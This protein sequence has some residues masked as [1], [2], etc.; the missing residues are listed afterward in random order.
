M[1][2]KT[3]ICP[4]SHLKAI[5]I[6]RL[7]TIKR[8][9]K[10]ILISTLGTTIASALGI[11]FYWMMLS[12]ID[13]ITNPITFDVFGDNYYNFAISGKSNDGFVSSIESALKKLFINDTKRQP[14]FFYF[15]SLNEMQ[16]FIYNHFD[17]K[18]VMGLDLSL[19]PSNVLILYNNT[20]YQG[21]QNPNSYEL[22]SIVLF[23]QALWFNE[24]NPNKT[25]Y[26]SFTSNSSNEPSLFDNSEF[27]FSYINFEYSSLNENMAK[28]IFSAIGPFLLVAGLLTCIPL[29]MYQPF[30]DIRGEVRQYMMQCTLRLFPYWFGTFIIDLSIWVIITTI[31]WGLLNL[32]WIRSFHDNLFSTW[33]VLAFQGPSMLLFFY[34][35]SFLFSSP[36]S[37]P[38][39]MYLIMVL[40]IFIGILVNMIIG[41][42]NPLGLDWFWSLIPPISLEQIISIIIRNMG[43]NKE[44]F[45]YYW[46]YQHS[47]PYLIMQ[48]VDIILYGIILAIIE[49][50]RIEIQ[51]R[52][53]KRTFSNYSEY[54]KQAKRRSVQ[55]DD[56]KEMEEAVHETNDWA[57]RI[58]DV[59][60]LFINNDKKPITAVNNVSLGIKEFSLFGFLGAN[61]AGK[62]TLINLI[63]GNIPPSAGKIELFGNNIEDIE[64]TTI[65]SIC[66]QFNSHLFLA[67]TPKEH[68]KIYSLL[69][70]M[71]DED[72]EDIIEDLISGMELNDFEDVPV[73]ELSIGDARKLGIALSFFGPSKL[74]ILD[75][76]TASLDPIACRCVQQ[77]ILEHKG[78]KT[79]ML[80]THILSEAEFLCDVISIMVR[81][82][83]YTIG[84]PQYLS[85]KYGKDYRI[86]INLDDATK[87]C[88]NKV[89]NFFNKELPDAELVIQRPKSQI[90]TIVL[91]S[92]E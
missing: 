83:I 63:A 17:S 55:S 23:G 66:P 32:G 14:N 35:F 12:W 6:R 75:E 58:V 46:H 60:R 45:R 62:T 24:F 4:L 86:D 40:A 27:N 85:E 50:N 10:S 48:W 67:L 9:W 84:S 19:G 91:C 34:C 88:H 7:L 38:R 39:I 3:G 37:G 92:K 57:V 18:L 42:I 90:Y 13:P 79:Y 54:F 61:G 30:L 56:A 65:I 36:I 47:M 49:V 44:N 89:R 53:A 69:F 22:Y 72:T 71:D 15:N 1:T 87:E 21:L 26:L 2:K 82:S 81:G 76:P 51:K 20:I 41:G 28:S 73:R 77:M 68:F 16:E 5:L 43:Y 52:L 8:S 78:E 70:Q 74:L 11:G 25:V 31:V 59:S 64:D 29:I 80:C 33:Y